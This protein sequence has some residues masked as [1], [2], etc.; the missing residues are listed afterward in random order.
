MGIYFPIFGMARPSFF[1]VLPRKAV[2]SEISENIFP[3]C[4]ISLAYFRLFF[5]Q[6]TANQIF[7]SGRIW[8]FYFVTAVFGQSSDQFKRDP[9][10]TTQSSSFQQVSELPTGYQYRF[11]D[12]LVGFLF[13]ICMIQLQLTISLLEITKL[14]NVQ[15]NQLLPQKFPPLPFSS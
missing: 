9:Y 11:I 4:L 1:R 13:L 3:Y 12:H 8:Y 2:P 6:L 7:Y 10:Y 15:R 14:N 5:I